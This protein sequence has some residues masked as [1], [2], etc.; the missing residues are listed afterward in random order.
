[1]KTPLLEVKSW[2]L[3]AQCRDANPDE[4]VPDQPWGDAARAIR[5]HCSRCPVVAECRTDAEEGQEFGVWAGE[6]RTQQRDRDG[7]QRAYT[8]A[9]LE[10]G[11]NAQKLS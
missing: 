7:R 6:Y 3:L 10:A 9:E 2:H 4:F 5:R 1:M 8:L 11:P